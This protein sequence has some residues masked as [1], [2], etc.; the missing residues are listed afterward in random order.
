MSAYIIARIKVTDPDR[1]SDYGA[2]A[3][4]LFAKH[5]GRFV[6]RGGR[7]ATLEGPQED[8][9][10]VVIAFPDRA[11]AEAFYNDAAYEPVRAIRWAAGES[12]LILVDGV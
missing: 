5:G 1:Y 11:A 2:A 8:R 4:A 9:R 6:V 12:E 3:P 7:P 10:V